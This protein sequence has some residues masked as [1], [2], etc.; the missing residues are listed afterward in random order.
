M[1]TTFSNTIHELPRVVTIEEL[2]QR[3]RETEVRKI[4]Q[5]VGTEVG[6][7]F[8]CDPDVW[9]RRLEK[10]IKAQTKPFTVDDCR[11]PNEQE[12]L[13]QHNCIFVRVIRPDYEKVLIR[14]YQE[15]NP[16]L[17]REAVAEQVRNA[18]L[19]PSE[20]YVGQLFHDFEIVA[21]DPVELYRQIE[22]KIG[23]LIGD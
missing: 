8:F 10:K 9:V 18:I 2:E 19:H 22:E 1:L 7:V 6:K 15:N 13:M 21:N 12:M 3:K 23:V 16:T 20:Q 14:Q 5:T 11:F 4:L 17:P